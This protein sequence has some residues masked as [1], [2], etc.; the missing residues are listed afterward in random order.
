MSNY[1]EQIVEAME[2][3]CA[4]TLTG[5]SQIN[6]IYDIE[7][8]SFKGNPTKYGVLPL[9]ISSI[10]TA[11]RASTGD[12]VIQVVLTDG[13]VN[14]VSNDISLQESVKTL[15]DK[16]NDLEKDVFSTKLGL[17]SLIMSANIESIGDPEVIEEHKIVTL[18]GDFLIRYRTPMC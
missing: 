1:V 10:V 15:F 2:A 4:I 6:Y 12:Q 9:G 14:T 18:R 8:N 16:M 13:Y 17:S 7:K 3:Q 11:M 5:F